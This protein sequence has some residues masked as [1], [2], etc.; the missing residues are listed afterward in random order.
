MLE[1]PQLHNSE[2]QDQAIFDALVIEDDPDSQDLMRRVLGGSHINALVV[3]NAEKALE[4]LQDFNPDIL[5]V[6][7]SLPGM[8]GLEFLERARRDPKNAETPAIAVTAYAKDFLPETATRDGLIDGYLEKPVDVLS[9]LS[10]VRGFASLAHLR[11]R[12]NPCTLCGRTNNPLLDV[13][14]SG[15]AAHL[16]NDSLSESV[17]RRTVYDKRIQS[18]SSGRS[19][20]LRYVE[21]EARWGTTALP[22]FHFWEGEAHSVPCPVCNQV[23]DPLMEVVAVTDRCVTEHGPDFVKNIRQLASNHQIPSRKSR[24]TWLILKTSLQNILHP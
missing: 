7:L 21:V 19:W 9:F 11:E 2:D 8:T 14:T 13:L 24:G 1:E 22:P 23:G 18:V 4:A 15:E 3:G 5:I 12:A 20:L 16:Y 6:D 17:I 10:R